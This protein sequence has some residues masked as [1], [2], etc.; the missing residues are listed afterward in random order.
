MKSASKVPALSSDGKTEDLSF[1]TLNTILFFYGKHLK[2]MAKAGIKYIPFFLIFLIYGKSVW[3]TD[4]EK[5]TAGSRSNVTD[6]VRLEAYGQ[7]EYGI[8]IQFYVCSRSIHD[9]KVWV[10]NAPVTG[11]YNDNG[12]TRNFNLFRYYNTKTNNGGND[13]AVVVINNGSTGV[14]YQ[15]FNDAPDMSWSD[16]TRGSI[17][18]TDG[19]YDL[20]EAHVRWY[21]PD[22]LIGRTLTIKDYITLG[23]NEGTASSSR[24]YY[25]SYQSSYSPD[26]SVSPSKTPGKMTVKYTYYGSIG[27]HGNYNYTIKHWMDINSGDAITDKT[28]TN[29]TGSLDVPI[30]NQQTTHYFYT[31][32]TGKGGYLSYTRSHQVTVPAYVW[33]YYFIATYDHKDSVRLQWFINTYNLGNDFIDND[34]FEIE[35]STDP[36]FATNKTTVATYTYNSSQSAYAIYDNLNNLK[37]GTKVYYR[38]RRTK[39]STDW[40][41]EKSVSTNVDVEM[42]STQQAD[43]AILVNDNGT[44]KAKI[45]WKPFRGVWTT[46]TKFSIKKSN[47]TTGVESATFD[48][49]EE[50]A[51][52]GEYIDE[53]ITYCNQFSYSIMITLGNGYPSPSET[54]VPGAVLAVNIG[55][56]SHLTA[57]KGYF[58][59]RTELQWHTQGQ[60]DNYI[61]KRKIY[62][63]SDDF[64]QIANI[65]GSSTSILQTDDS[66]GAPGVYYQYMVLGAVKCNNEL[67]YSQD[68]LYAIGFRAP[69]GNIYGRITYENGQAVENVAV[70]LQNNDG[71]QLGQSISLNGNTSSYLKIDSLNTPFEDS[72]FTIE[73]WIRPDNPAPKSQVIFSRK[74]QYELGFDGDGKLYFSYNGT[75]VTGTYFNK[76]QVYV[77]V[78][79]IHSQDSL[80]LMINDSVIAKAPVAFTSANHKAKVVF[81]GRNSAGNN[82][83]GYIDEMIAWNIARKPGQIAKDYTLLLTGGEK[84]LAAYWRFDETITDQFYDISHKGEKYNRNDGTMNASAV[85]HAS[86]I[87]DTYQLSLKAYTDSTGNYMISGV[88]YSGQGTTYTIVPLFGTHQFDPISVNRLISAGSPSFTVDFTDK[89][90]FPVTG[91]VYYFN[92]NVPVPGVQFLIDGKY[93]QQ[94]NGDLLQTGNDGKFTI[95]VPVGIHEVKAVKNNHIF[96]NLGKITDRHGNDRNYQEP[97]GPFVIYDSTTIRFIGRVAGGTVQQAYPL[98]HSLSTNNLGKQ[99]QVILQLPSGTKYDLYK[100]DNADSTIYVDHLLPSNQ[101]D[102]SKIHKTRVVY[103]KVKD[104][105]IIYPD[106]LTGEFE[107]DLIPEKFIAKSVNATGWGDLLEGKPV[108]LDFTN[109]FIT[110]YAVHAYQDSSQSQDGGWNYTGYEDSVAYNDSYQFIKRV[111]PSVSITQLN[112][113]GEEVNYFGDTAYSYQS[114]N[115][116]T[117]DIPVVDQSKSGRQVYLFGYPVFTQSKPYSFKINAYE[118]YPFYE[119]VKQDGTP[120]MAVKN[121]KPVIDKVPTSDGDVSI[122]NSIRNGATQADTLSLDSTGTGYYDF[123]AGDPEIALPGT[124][125]F[126]V[127]IRFGGATDVSWS[128]LG[129]PKMQAFVMGAKL[130]GTDFVTAGPNKILMVL[131]DPPGNKSYSYVQSGSTVSNTSTYTGTV[132]QVGDIEAIATVGAKVITWVGVGA[133]TINVVEAK[134]VA[135][136]TVHHEEHYIGSNTKANSTTFTT[137][138]QTSGDPTFVGAP[139]D[140]YVGYSTNITYGKSNN[141]V[142]I[143]RKDMKAT[144]LLIYQASPTSSNVVVSREGINFGQK[145]GTLFAY[146]QQ[147]IVKILIPNLIDVRNSLL[148]PPTTSPA[149]A[150]QKADHDKTAVYV[151]KLAAGDPNFGKS[152]SD[153]IAFGIKAKTDL[154]GDGESYKIYYPQSSD[155]RTDTIMI[156]NQY[157]H[158][159]QEEIAR[160]EEEK[161]NSKSHLIQNYS[162]HA[163]NPISYSETKKYDH[164]TTNSFNIILSAKTVN[165]ATTKIQGA[166]VVFKFNEAIGTQ[167]GGSFGE[168]SDT[169]TTMGFELASSGTDEYISVDVNAAQREVELPIGIKIPVFDGFV[170]TTKGGQTSCPYEGTA[171][172]QYYQPGTVLGQPTVQIE[173]PKIK[174]DNPIVNNV[175]STKKASYTLYLTNESEAKLPATFVL[176]YANT[177]SIKGAYIAV[178]G[179]SIAGGRAFAVQYGQTVKKVLTLAKGPDAMDYNNIPLILHSSCQYDPTGYQALIADTVLISAHF[180]PS[181]SNI[182]VKSPNDKWILNTLSQVNQ[183]GKRYLPVTLNDFDESNSL[184]D[185]IELQYKPS[186]TSQWITT[187][188]FFGDSAKYKAAQGDKAFITNA[189]EINYNLELD[190]GSFNDQPYDIRALAVC[191]LGPGNYINTPS[192]VITGIKDTYNPRLFG[193]PEPANGVLG[194]EDNIKLKFNELIASGL[195]TPA[196]FQVTGIRNGTKGDHSVS[197]QL[198][199]QND[200]IQSEFKKNLTGRNLT[201]EMW[202]LPDRK[203]NGTVFSYG[204]LNESLELAFTQNNHLQVTVGAKTITSDKSLEQYGYQPGNWAHIALEYNAEDSTVSAFYNFQAVIHQAQVSAYHGMGPIIFGRS[205]HKEANYFAGKIHEAR[206]WT[207]LI[208]ATVLQTNSLVHLSGYEDG[209]LAYYPINEGRGSIAFDKAHGNNATIT[210]S[211]ST[212]PGKAMALNGNGYISLPS[213]TAPV[214]SGMDYTLG[215]WFKAKP[216]Q[217]D[218]AL[219]SNGKGDGADPGTT[220]SKN[221]F[222]LGFE[223]GLLTFENNGIKIQV[224]GKYDDNQWHHVAIAVNRTAGT[225]R[226]FVDDTLKRFFNTQNLGGIASAA[227]YLGA[228]GYLTDTNAVTPTFDRYFEGEIDEFRLWNTYLNQSLLEKN[229]NVR[230]KGDELGLMLYYPFETYYEFQGQK[231]MDSSLMDQK[232]QEGPNQFTLYATN[233]KAAFTNDMAPIKDRGPV[234]NLNFSFVVNNDELI[235]NL[236][237][238]RQAVDKTIVT[239]RVKDVKDMH[240]NP[241]LS[242]ITW[243]AYIDRN[244]LNWSDDEINLDKDLYASLQFTSYVINTGGNNENFTLDNLPAWLT[245]DVTSGTVPPEGKQKITFTVNEGLNVGTYNEIA[246]MTNDNG[247]TQ[248][249]PINIKVKGQ[250]PDWKVDPA[251]FKYSMN[252]YGKIRIDGIFSDDK[253]DM[254]AAFIN[255]KCVGVTHNTYFSNNDLWYAL[256]TIYSNNIQNNDIEFRIWDASTGKVYAGIPS[257]TVNFVNDAIIGTPRQPVIFDGKELLFQNI[258]LNKGWNWISFNLASSHLN[259]INTTLVNGSWHSGDIVK[260]DERGFDQYSNTNGW[261]G[262]LPGFDNTSLFKLQTANPQTLSTNG[263]LINVKETPISVR[264]NRWSYISY[265]PQVNMTLKEALAD[266]HAS[267]GDVIKSQTGFSMYDPISGWVGNLTYLQPGQGYMIFRK[268]NSDVTFV[269]P[270]FSGSLDIHRLAESNNS[271]ERLNPYQIPVAGNYHFA[272]NMTMI[273]TVDKE[274]TLQPD[275]KILAYTGD[276]LRGEAQAIHNPVINM[277]SFFFNISGKEHL[278]VYFGVER[279]GKI[280]ARTQPVVSY[281][282][283]SRIGSLKEPF[284]LHFEKVNAWNVHSEVTVYPNPFHDKIN[285]FVTLKTSAT[286]SPHNVQM[287]VWNVAGQ[288]IFRASKKQINNGYYHTTWEGKNTSGTDCTPGIY[289]IHML[290]DE[291]PYVY[292]VIKY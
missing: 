159:W 242:P 169:T 123:T 268:A 235:I 270:N 223:N 230:L 265:L 35:R 250:V 288:E 128:W 276:D 70:R 172:T 256:L 269:Y 271:I 4:H 110:Q 37:G 106:S 260:H 179:A 264:G 177:D 190:D 193:S 226:F 186:A 182:S 125:D 158:G 82:F 163:G 36:T 63:S 157:I 155:Y 112:G 60:F 194:I 287:S 141:L 165:S 204:N 137:R 176:S 104:Q 81:I 126:A 79:G 26:F 21:V 131:R 93:A 97:G 47:R 49:T 152:N 286:T 283:N 67:K 19:G 74:G 52:S 211:W 263:T 29:P 189:Q 262:T 168:S 136:V 244:P 105:I 272:N 48:L 5:I 251:A 90:S 124:K 238:P 116:N 188:N 275:D 247:E 147:H 11:T 170:F 162:F 156:L 215:L 221:L 22:Y 259:N 222:Y 144:D 281:M 248:A 229:N 246:Y 109:K 120:V 43:T 135:D 138:F 231:E 102:S 68:T 53:N 252:I 183:Q 192:N 14:R 150:Q 234:D 197:L 225:G 166:G 199:G 148:L 209:L 249:L 240:G 34:N 145:F 41:W 217:T 56:I 206:I 220:G 38:L 196:D 173:V 84:G 64:I 160:N 32:F 27:V 280:I 77:H 140:L 274:F 1:F 78:A 119:S 91:Y 175:P 33:P 273:A 12:V 267:E 218:A 266:Y 228:R 73:A 42:N 207:Q 39:T 202:V 103:D 203:E 13:N 115:G 58:P 134:T 201:V 71:T 282:A 132:D 133:G 291:K 161:I 243:T 239:F 88:P 61:V 17:W 108:S 86:L 187:M 44:P 151:S 205:I 184:F 80:L 85:K 245:A 154:V 224:D 191:Q 30:N 143:K 96:M 195:L 57:S 146:P 6:G 178:D 292:K 113:S 185:H 284:M 237:E 139:A 216:G 31:R 24:N 45:T 2:K 167:Q 180:V 87:P 164:S 212:P 213:G 72:A 174:V 62:G 65:S 99:L 227:I 95:S 51:R 258:E 200:F 100:G 59:D 233:V 257:T 127:S 118:A 181:C 114:L 219:A 253:D 142:I 28:N 18:K 8:Y 121:E 46:G 3:A 40:N 130:T 25:V 254:L 208:P 15:A 54:D 232:I 9:G 89:S 153:T 66:K 107:A 76:N 214:T 117:Q 236:L 69:T 198:D 98:G 10:Y 129:N 16:F 94:G 7:D 83:K 285:I 122:N 255:G 20:V 290:I 23:D 149:E 289:F 278:P 279:N 55:T 261:V 210:G 111:I 277:A 75:P 50:Q 92:S 171:T 101:T 241:L